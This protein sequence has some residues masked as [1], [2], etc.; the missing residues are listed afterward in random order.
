[1]HNKE[2]KTLENVNDGWN[3]KITGKQGCQMRYFN[4]R[5]P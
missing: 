2:E 4:G 3:E 5:E 1:M